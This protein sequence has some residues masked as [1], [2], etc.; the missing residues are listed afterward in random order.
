MNKKQKKILSD[1][2]FVLFIFISAITPVFSS[3]TGIELLTGIVSSD[4][5]EAIQK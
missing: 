4:I 2:A 5:Q 3:K 1:V